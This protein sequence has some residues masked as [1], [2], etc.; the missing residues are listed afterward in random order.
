MRPLVELDVTLAQLASVAPGLLARQQLGEAMRTIAVGR[1]ALVVLTTMPHDGVH[2]ETIDPN[3]TP[4]PPAHGS[5][6]SEGGFS[7]GAK[8]QTES[9][10]GSV[11]G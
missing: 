9:S 5:G 11:S 2:T 7:G 8:G 6:Y 1:K 10:S 4:T 3:R